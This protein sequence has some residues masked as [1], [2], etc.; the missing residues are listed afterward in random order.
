MGAKKVVESA[1]RKERGSS[2]EKGEHASGGWGASDGTGVNVQLYS[3]PHSNRNHAGSM[4]STVMN[5]SGS[6]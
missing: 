5:P 1:V 2:S 4:Q 6:N 3:H